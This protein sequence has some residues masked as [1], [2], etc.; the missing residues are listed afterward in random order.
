ML[1]SPYEKPLKEIPKMK[2][3]YLAFFNQ[4]IAGIGVNPQTC[5]MK[6]T[7][8]SI[9]SPL[10][11]KKAHFEWWINVQKKELKVCL[12]FDSSSTANLR[13]F[14][15]CAQDIPKLMPKIAGTLTKGVRAPASSMYHISVS[16][17]PIDLANAD[18]AV[19]TMRIF[20]EVFSNRL[21]MLQ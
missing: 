17:S 10:A 1:K 16:N 19:S 3:E 7:Y 21:E 11:M 15:A 14:D 13:R 6:G 18:W 8:C 20:Q 4:C 9:P 2:P 12:H 5:V